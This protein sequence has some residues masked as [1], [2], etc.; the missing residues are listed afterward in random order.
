[1]SSEM[2]VR[3]IGP[4]EYELWDE[5]V[6]IS[7]YGTIFQK[8]NWLTICKDSF[9][10]DL[11]MY[12]CFH[13]DELV[14]GCSLFSYRVRRI[15]RV[16]SSYC[17]MTPYGGILVKRSA[18]KKVR[19]QEEFQNNVLKN[20][21]KHI[22]EQGYDSVSISN[23]PDFIDTRQFSSNKWIKDIRYSYYF[24]LRED[25][26]TRMP[27][28]LKAI[29]RKANENGILVKKED[30]LQRFYELINQTYERQQLIP[31]AQMNFYEKIM[32]F[33]HK[34]HQGE[35][36]IAEMPTGEVVA[37]EIII[38][39]NK[40]AHRWAATSNPDLKSHNATSLLLHN[41]FQDLKSRNFKEINLMSGNTPKLTKFITGFNPELVP[42]YVVS[43]HSTKFDVSLHIIN[44]IR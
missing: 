1:M 19:N 7:P 42:Y 3:E 9:N 20:I 32:D 6:E 24:D 41:I 14:G 5:M 15:F 22:E 36:W 2:R 38:W 37:A 10:F 33:L 11:K 44:Y 35:M 12:G 31:P 18:S 13:K 43:R 30:D 25:I 34:T 26:E 8:S 40:R 4:D 17:N 23:P 28:G 39:D 21:L 27:K 16:A 29:I